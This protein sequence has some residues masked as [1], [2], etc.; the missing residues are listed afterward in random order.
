MQFAATKKTLAWAGAW[1][2]MGIVAQSDGMAAG[3]VIAGFLGVPAALIVDWRRSVISRRPQPPQ[4]LLSPP[5]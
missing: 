3:G 5:R 4:L 1:I 2:F